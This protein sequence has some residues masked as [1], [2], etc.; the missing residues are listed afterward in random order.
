MR[1]AR[2][3]GGD[4]NPNSHPMLARRWITLAASSRRAANRPF[5]ARGRPGAAPKGSAGAWTTALSGK[6]RSVALPIWDLGRKEPCCGHCFIQGCP[7]PRAAPLAAQASSGQRRRRRPLQDAHA[8]DAC[9]LCVKRC[10]NQASDR[11]APFAP[12]W[13]WR[14]AH[15]PQE[16]QPWALLCCCLPLRCRT[17][18]GSLPV[19][20]KTLLPFFSI[21]MVGKRGQPRSFSPSFYVF[22]NA[23]M[24]K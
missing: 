23:F 14:W 19:L 2:K 13:C 6:R 7:W 5:C 1:P 24:K 3:A 16:A 4:P 20:A 12:C 9:L 22:F 11:D 8:S 18:W 10:K 15:R 21:P 17:H